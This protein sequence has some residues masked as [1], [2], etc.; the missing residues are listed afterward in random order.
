MAAPV[1]FDISSE[2]SQEI[3]HPCFCEFASEQ[4]S[5]F[6]DGPHPW[7]LGSPT[8]LQGSGAAASPS[9]GKRPSVASRVV[10]AIKSSPRMVRK[11][12]QKLRVRACLCLNVINSRDPFTRTLLLVCVC[13][14]ARQQPVNTW[15]AACVHKKIIFFLCRK[16]L[17]LICLMQRDV[18]GTE[19]HSK[20]HRSLFS[21]VLTFRR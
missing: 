3:E 16:C 18:G 11:A 20:L 15:M 10:K 8:L 13:V 1:A 5:A 4:N 2:H 12:I 7:S 21:C 19:V 6:C 9:L 17:A 14:C